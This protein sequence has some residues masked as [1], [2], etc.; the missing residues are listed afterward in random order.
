MAPAM[1]SAPQQVSCTNN[2]EQGAM[3]AHR[4]FTS[5]LLFPCCYRRGHA[6]TISVDGGSL[7]LPGGQQ[8]TAS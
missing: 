4:L 8:V 3:G 2:W 1:R 6:V 7:L 5:S